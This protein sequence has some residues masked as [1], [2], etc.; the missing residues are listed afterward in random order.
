MGEGDDGKG[1]EKERRR[2]RK[3]GRRKGKESSGKEGESK[4]G[5]CLQFL[6]GIIG[7]G[8]I[9]DLHSFTHSFIYFFLSPQYS[10]LEG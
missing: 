2:E 6:G 4:E 5:N 7:P 1:R 8:L 9:A 10:I 3:K